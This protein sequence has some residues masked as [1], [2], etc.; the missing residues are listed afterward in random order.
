MNVNRNI[1]MDHGGRRNEHIVGLCLSLFSYI[2]NL[3]IVSV[4]TPRGGL[5]IE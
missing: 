5:L 4:K 3:I 1:L 2:A